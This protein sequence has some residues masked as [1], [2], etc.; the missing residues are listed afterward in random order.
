MT[1]IKNFFQ[2][3]LCLEALVG[4]LL[5]LS[6]ICQFRLQS[7]NQEIVE[8]QNEITNNK[9]NQ[10][11]NQSSDIQTKLFISDQSW[12]TKTKEKMKGEFQKAIGEENDKF[13]STNADKSSIIGDYQ[14]KQSKWIFFFWSSIG[15]SL[16]LYILILERRIK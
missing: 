2:E 5:I 3:I 4:I 11:M 14:G 15:F 16:I 8:L 12:E 9:I 13:E 7:L 1:L 10:T 6:M